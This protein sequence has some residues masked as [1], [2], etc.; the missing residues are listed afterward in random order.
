MNGKDSRCKACVAEI[1]KN[2]RRSK[3]KSEL[4]SARYKQQ[5]I[6]VTNVVGILTN[7]ILETT[8]TLIGGSISEL[9]EKGNLT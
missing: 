7:Q 5:H 6:L 2:N 3:L 9:I 8:G 1:K 4:R